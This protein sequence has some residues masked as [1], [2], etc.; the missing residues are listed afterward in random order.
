MAVQSKQTSAGSGSKDA[1][2]EVPLSIIFQRVFEF[3]REDLL[4]FLK[5]RIVTRDPTKL[6]V[7]W[8]ITVP[9]IWDDEG[10]DFMRTAAFKAGALFH[11][12]RVFVRRGAYIRYNAGLIDSIDSPNLVLALEPECAILASIA[13]CT[14]TERDGFKPGT[15]IMVVDC[16]G[17]TVDIT[18]DKV[19][20][21]KPLCLREVRFI[22][23][24]M[25][26]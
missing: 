1:A 18:I 15:N 26:K 24:P 9:A 20:S 25:P 22:L 17:G 13:D 6:K 8:V 23:P 3:V 5:T 7:L 2:P 19:E 4:A 10:K 14:P 16:G 12:F 21:I 11:A